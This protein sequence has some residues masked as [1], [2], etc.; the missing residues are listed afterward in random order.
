M[1]VTCKNKEVANKRVVAVAVETCGRKAEEETS[2]AEVMV[3]R[4]EA[5]EETSSAGVIGMT[6]LTHLTY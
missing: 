3:C 1:V 5:A 4:S 6:N 2:S